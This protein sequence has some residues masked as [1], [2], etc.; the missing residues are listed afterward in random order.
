MACR[1]T[2]MMIKLGNRE[3]HLWRVTFVALRGWMVISFPDDWLFVDLSDLDA[4]ETATQRVQDQAHPR[5]SLQDHLGGIT[6]AFSEWGLQ[7]HLMHP[8]EWI[9]FDR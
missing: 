7:N 8:R 9:P 6:L 4:L 5:Y 1:R 2:L 3:S